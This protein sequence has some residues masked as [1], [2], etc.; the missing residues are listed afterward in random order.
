[1]TNAW[2]NLQ[3]TISTGIA[4]NP[5][6][7]ALWKVSNA[8]TDVVEGIAIPAISV[9]G[10]MVDLN[11]NIASLMKVGAIGGGLL[12]GI[13]NMI[14]GTLGGSA[15]GFSGSGMLKALGITNNNNITTITRGSG[16][17]TRARWCYSFRICCNGRQY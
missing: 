13:G 4:S 1:M 12:S 17:G 3:Y 14:A 9:M 10:N 2:E 7:F 16:L 8:L 15:G 11:T 6:L 5:A